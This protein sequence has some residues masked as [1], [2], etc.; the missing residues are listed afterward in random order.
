MAKPG[1][2]MPPP[3]KWQHPAFHW[4]GFGRKSTKPPWYD[5]YSLDKTRRPLEGWEGGTCGLRHEV[6]NKIK[7]ENPPY[8]HQPDPRIYRAQM[9]LSRTILTQTRPAGHTER[10]IL[11]LADSGHD[12]GYEHG[13]AEKY[14][15]GAEE[16]WRGRMQCSENM[17]RAIMSE[18]KQTIQGDARPIEKPF[19]YPNNLTHAMALSM[20]KKAAPNPPFDQRPPTPEVKGERSSQHMYI[21]FSRTRS[22]FDHC[23]ERDATATRAT[24]WQQPAHEPS[25][26]LVPKGVAPGVPP[27]GGR[28]SLSHSRSNPI[29]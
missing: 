5:V 10:H 28:L 11:S 20:E 19:L 3:Q 12:A 26:R 9:P 25:R 29:F 13:T 6:G 17:R 23:R 22:D 4:E 24:S 21:G 18:M 16:A 27:A 15:K 2:S 7:T 14:G 8:V 1:F